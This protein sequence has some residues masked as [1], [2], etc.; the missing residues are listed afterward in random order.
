MFVRSKRSKLEALIDFHTLD[1][2]IGTESHLDNSVLNTEV[3]PSHYDV[4]RQDRN[5][6]EGGVFILIKHKTP[7][8]FLQSSS[9]DE[10]IW[11]HIQ[12]KYTQDI[13][14]C[15]TVFQWLPALY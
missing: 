9:S 1:F 13:L 10:L 15:F 12:L 3:C 2:V 6:H 8:L 14:G 4:Y 11:V 7:S 5:R